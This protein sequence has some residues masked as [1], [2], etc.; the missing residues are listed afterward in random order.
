M[1]Q[2]LHVYDAGTWELAPFVYVRDG[3][4]WREVQEGYV[5]ESGVW[6]QFHQAFIASVSPT[7]V[8]G[9]RTGGGQVQT[10]Q[11]FVSVTGGVGPFTFFWDI[12]SQSGDVTATN[13]A[14]NTTIAGAVEATFSS[15]GQS[16]SGTFR[17]TVTDTGTGASVVSPL[18]NFSLVAI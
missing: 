13:V 11:S 8:T 15:G 10:N 2:S 18:V 7:T 9:I 16:V 1:T 5:R 3:G 6:K 17:C 12:V 4:V 14:P